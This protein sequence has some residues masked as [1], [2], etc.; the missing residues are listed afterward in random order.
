MQGGMSSSTHAVDY[1]KSLYGTPSPFP[2]SFDGNP[3]SYAFGLFGD[4]VA[5]S[6]ATAI[7]LSFVF[8][9][10]RFRQVHKILG[11]VPAPTHAVPWTPLWLYRTGMICF[12]SFVVMRALPDALWML[13]WGEVEVETIE[14]LLMID[15]LADGFSIIP[16]FAA[17]LAWAWGRQVIPQKLTEGRTAIVSGRP[18]WDVVLKNGR[19]VL[20]VIVISILVTIGKASG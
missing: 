10:R 4:I 20:V 14:L 12:L 7:L 1:V 11:I 5:A 16:L 3:L 2:P 15:L 6:L 17:S 19:I 13:A 8:E 9:K 18:P